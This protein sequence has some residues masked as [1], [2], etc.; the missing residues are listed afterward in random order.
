L[1]SSG[2]PAFVATALSSPPPSP[3]P[4][5]SCYPPLSPSSQGPSP[6]SSRQDAPRSPSQFFPCR[7]PW[8]SLPATPLD[9]PSA[10]SCGES[11]RLWPGP[12]RERPQSSTPSADSPRRKR[13]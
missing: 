7:L 6:S 4:P 8:P 10:T 12:S 2:L 1:Q 5:S 11:C 13:G 3:P 9:S